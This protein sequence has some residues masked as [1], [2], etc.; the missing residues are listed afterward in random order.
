[1]RKT[2]L[3]WVLAFI[4]TLASAVYQR[5]TGPTYP[6]SGRASFAGR[7]FKYRLA[8]SHGGNS[9]QPVELKTG[10]PEIAGDLVWRRFRTDDAWTRVPM[11]FSDGVLKGELPWQPPAGKLE[12][13]VELS[14][15]GQSASVPGAVP[16]VTR[17]KGDVPVSILI[18]HVIAMFGGMLLS[19][20]AGLEFLKGAGNLRSLILWTIGFL[21]VGGA[22]LGPVVQKYAFD[23]YWT[24]W[25]F[26]TDL[27]DNKTAV[28]LAAWAGVYF[29][30]K[31]SRRPQL[32]ATVAAVITLAV[33]MIPHSLLGSELDY[34]KMDKP[35]ASLSIR[36]LDS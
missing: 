18:L 22:I 36:I 35:T 13:R 32:W 11:Q 17:F 29:A 24:G 25:P 16:V 7:E 23:A 30:L 12:Y 21:A 34:K 14:A 19:T 6:V 9:N 1:M 27:T 26:G 3:L 4:I 28:A 20:R 5:L 31:H 2:V 10:D 8:R 33:F 15:R